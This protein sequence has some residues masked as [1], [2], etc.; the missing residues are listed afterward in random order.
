VDEFTNAQKVS[1]TITFGAL[2]GKTVGDADFTVSATAT[3]GLA[4]SFTA[5]GPCTVA[6]NTVHITGAGTCTITA[7]QGGNAN[8]ASAPNV[9]SPS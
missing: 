7:S 1:Q 8:Y 4:V 3:S 2:A 5:S 6:G 9:R